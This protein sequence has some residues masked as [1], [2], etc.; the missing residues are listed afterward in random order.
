MQRSGESA[1]SIS[2]LFSRKRTMITLGIESSCDE[3]SVALLDDQCILAN[4]IYSQ[5]EH[6]AYGGV[7]PEVASRAHLE[8]IDHL[9]SAVLNE[10]SLTIRQVDL[11]AVT[12]SPGLAGA[13]LIGVSFALGLAGRYGTPICGINHLEGHICAIFLEHPD[14]GFPFLAVVVSGG[15]TAIYRVDAIGAYTCLGRTVDDAAGEAFDKAGKMLGFPYP[16]GRAIEEEASRAGEGGA[17][18][19]PVARIRGNALD[20]SF[21]GLKTALKYYLQSPGAAADRPAVCRAFQDAVVN[22]LVHNTADAAD[23][24]GINR[25]ALVGGVACNGRLR[26]ALRDRP[27]MQ[28]YFPSPS[29]CTDNGAMIACAGF[30]RFSRNLLR[31][32]RM[33]PGGTISLPGEGI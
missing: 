11:I 32:P 7:V 14:I 10:A 19:F 25:I 12:D 18:R 33:D 15:H 4:R 8:K 22:S 31:P 20:F 29:L 21:S 5:A 16:A 30:N 17:P 3:T 28:V 6:G 1:G 23:A 9:T 26:A 13:L 27:G 24:T 2:T